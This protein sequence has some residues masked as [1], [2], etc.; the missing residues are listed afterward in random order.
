M[1]GKG[2]RLWFGNC[3]ALQPLLP[4]PEQARP[5]THPVGGL[6]GPPWGEVATI[7]RGYIGVTMAS[8]PPRSPEV[9][10]ELLGL[11]PQLDS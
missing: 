1:F 5:P 3:R 2:R 7:L 10:P 11:F 9:P 6:A 4:K 8:A